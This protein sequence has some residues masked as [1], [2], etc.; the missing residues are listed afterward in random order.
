M[1]DKHERTPQRSVNFKQWNH[2]KTF[3][4]TQDPRQNPIKSISILAKK[5]SDLRLDFERLNSVLSILVME[6]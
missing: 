3:R 4:I 1:L 2:T 6:T 5:L